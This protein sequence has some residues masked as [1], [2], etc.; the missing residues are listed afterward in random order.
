MQQNRRGI[1]GLT[2][3]MSQQPSP[4]ATIDQMEPVLILSHSYTYFAPR[5][6]L[7]VR[8][9]QPMA[10]TLGAEAMVE[11]DEPHRHC[12]I[13]LDQ[14]VEDRVE[15]DPDSDDAVT[16]GKSVPIAPVHAAIVL[17]DG[18]LFY[19]HLGALPS[20]VAAKKADSRII[21]KPGVVVQIGLGQSVGL[22]VTE[23]AFGQPMWWYYVRVFPLKYLKR[24]LSAARAGGARGKAKR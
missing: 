18:K 13:Q 8:L 20:V 2:P 6:I 23:D 7:A 19:K 4:P 5:E 12:H 11:I 3:S 21:R 24:Q 16:M 10:V 1:R 22:G 17:Q 9:M 15:G 14:S